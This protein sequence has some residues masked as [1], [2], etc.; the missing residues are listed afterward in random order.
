VII[1]NRGNRKLRR[2]IERVAGATI[3]DVRSNIATKTAAAR[4]G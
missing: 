1:L 2:K 3:Y 4:A